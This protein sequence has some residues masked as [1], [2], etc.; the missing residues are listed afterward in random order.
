MLADHR[1]HVFARSDDYFFGVLHS[2]AHE[3]RS[4][5][6]GSTLEDRPTYVSS[7]CF[8]TFPPPKA[9]PKQRKT[10]EAAANELNELREQ[11]LNPKGLIGDKD[12]K[13]RT[14]TSLYSER[15][16]WLA[17]AHAA[18]DDAVSA[19]YGWKPD[20]DDGEILSRLLELNL[21]QEPA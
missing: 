10:I 17:N 1:L 9:G 12:L 8:E 3:V 5:A 16:T 21:E 6:L 2:R 15:P 18:L 7:T 13:K 20:L 14:Q 11:W 19:A 4:L